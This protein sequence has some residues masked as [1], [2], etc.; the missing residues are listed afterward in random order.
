VGA[1]RAARDRARSSRSLSCFV[2]EPV[3]WP[4]SAWASEDR[5]GKLRAPSAPARR[6]VAERSRSLSIP[7]KTRNRKKSGSSFRVVSCAQ[8]RRT[9]SRRMSVGRRSQA[10]AHSPLRCA[11]GSNPDRNRSESATRERPAD[12]PTWSLQSVRDCQVAPATVVALC[13]GA[14]RTGHARPWGWLAIAS[15][16]SPEIILICHIGLISYIRPQWKNICP[17]LLYEHASLA[18]RTA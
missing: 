13:P 17:F 1:D 9:S 10:S 3:A 4:A 8:V 15:T 18:S 2:R 12:S 6:C 5:A 11:R 7:A 16:D 14:S